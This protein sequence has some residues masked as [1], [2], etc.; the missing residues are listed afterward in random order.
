VEVIA[1]RPE[2]HARRTDAAVR[3]LAPTKAV[4]RQ[5]RQPTVMQRYAAFLEG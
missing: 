3:L 2:T 5:P 4:D 1:K